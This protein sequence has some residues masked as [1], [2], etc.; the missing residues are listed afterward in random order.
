MG[1]RFFQFGILLIFPIYVF[2]MGPKGG[3]GGNISPNANLTVSSFTIT[4]QLV[5]GSGAS[6]S[7]FTATAL[8]LDDGLSIQMGNSLSAI[9]FVSSCDISVDTPTVTRAL[10]MDSSF[11]LY[12]GTQVTTA[13]WQKIGAQ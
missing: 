7:T 9:R 3:A 4:N 6:K 5:V 1:I 12:V 8:Q 2:G 11:I 13:S 10:C